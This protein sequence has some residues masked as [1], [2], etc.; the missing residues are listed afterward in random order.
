MEKKTSSYFRHLFNDAHYAL[1]ITE[2]GK[3][4]NYILINPRIIS[5]S[6]K[7]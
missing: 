3:F 2:D 1:K 4:D 6:M 7:I 5:N